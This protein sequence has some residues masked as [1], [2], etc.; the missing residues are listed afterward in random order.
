MR[1]LRVKE[2]GARM[3]AWFCIRK[4]DCLHTGLDLLVFPVTIPDF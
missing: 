3:A 1:E 2:K 4:K